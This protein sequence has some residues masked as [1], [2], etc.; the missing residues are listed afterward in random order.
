[1]FKKR[2]RPYSLLLYLLG[3]V[4]NY[5]YNIQIGDSVCLFKQCFSC[6]KCLSLII[7]QLKI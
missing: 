6:L 7:K 5:I 3:I 1:M 4:V 2:H